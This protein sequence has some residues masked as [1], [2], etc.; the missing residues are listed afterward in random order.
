MRR[1]ESVA[2]STCVLVSLAILTSPAKA[3]DYYGDGYSRPRHSNAWYSSDCCYK[4]IVRHERSVHYRRVDEDRYHDRSSYQD[5]SY[6][7]SYTYESPR[8]Y[9]NDGYSRYGYSRPGYSSSGY[10]SYADSC[11]RH[12]VQIDDGRGGWVWGAKINCY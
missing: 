2:L 8:R 12:R 4:K 9:V 6:R 1:V 7:R 10:S 5:R 3:G 11:H